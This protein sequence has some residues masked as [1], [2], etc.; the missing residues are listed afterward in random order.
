MIIFL[1]LQLLAPK[2][3]VTP[4]LTRQLSLSTI[5]NTK[6]GLD[7]R[8]VTIAMKKKVFTLYGI[9]WENRKLYEVDHLIP[10]ELGGADDVRNLWPQLWLDA[11]LKDKEENRLYRVVCMGLGRSGVSLMDAQEQ[12]RA[13]NRKK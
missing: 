11:H 2:I 6:W 5:C 13:W 7:H 10:R 1:V 3:S 9:P 12:M 8:H 4:G